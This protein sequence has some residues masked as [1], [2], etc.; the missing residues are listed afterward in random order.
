MMLK[1][2]HYP[3]SCWI[4]PLKLHTER[5]SL[6]FGGVHLGC[7]AV[8]HQNVFA[9]RKHDTTDAAGRDGKPQKYVSTQALVIR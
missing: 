7:A 5:G 6:Y 9:K 2:E 4:K 3:F 8:Q 1:L